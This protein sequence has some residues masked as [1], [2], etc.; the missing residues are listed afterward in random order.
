MALCVQTTHLLG[1][2]DVDL[3]ERAPELLRV[4]LQLVQSLGLMESECWV[5]EVGLAVVREG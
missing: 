5:D 1:R 3:T 4:H 2:R